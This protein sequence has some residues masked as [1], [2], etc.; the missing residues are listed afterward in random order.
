ML[1]KQMKQER[2]QKLLRTEYIAR[3]YPLSKQALM[4]FNGRFGDKQE[5]TMHHENFVQG[6]VFSIEDLYGIFRNK[7]AFLNNLE[8]GKDFD[9]EITDIIH[10]EY[11]SGL[12]WDDI[13]KL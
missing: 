9:I 6:R 5:M 13:K 12:V 11:D 1:F 7:S 8:F 3:V 4:D 2:E 10:H